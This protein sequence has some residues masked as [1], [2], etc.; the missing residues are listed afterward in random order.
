[1]GW[2]LARAP[3]AWL[4]TALCGD[5]EGLM[6]ENPAITLLHLRGAWGFLF[7]VNGLVMQPPTGRAPWDAVRASCPKSRRDGGVG[8]SRGC[9]CAGDPAPHPGPRLIPGS[10]I[11]IASRKGG[12]VF[13]LCLAQMR[14]FPAVLLSAGIALI[15]LLRVNFLPSRC[16]FGFRM[17][18]AVTHPPAACH[19]PLHAVG[20]WAKLILAA[21]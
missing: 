18:P 5:S 15:Y 8:P 14:S 19:P 4:I 7:P 1:M 20:P 6:P 2:V 21:G 3:G 9:G 17:S 10:G 11:P 13:L 12:T 16:W